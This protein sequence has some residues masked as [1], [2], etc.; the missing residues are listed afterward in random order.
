M[1]YMRKKEYDQLC[2]VIRNSTVIIRHICRD[3]M[4]PGTLELEV[5]VQ[6]QLIEEALRNA[7]TDSCKNPTHTD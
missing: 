1:P 5:S 4:Y 3:H 7:L 6:L 2:H